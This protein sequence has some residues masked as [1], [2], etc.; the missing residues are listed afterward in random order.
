MPKM[1]NPWLALATPL[2]NR[3]G[4]G[5]ED[6]AT[7]KPAKHAA[8][9]PPAPTQPSRMAIVPQELVEMSVGNPWT[10]SPR[11]LEVLHLAVRGMNRAQIGAELG[12]QLHTVSQHLSLIRQKMYVAT[13]A[14]AVYAWHQYNRVIQADPAENKDNTLI[15]NLQRAIASMEKKTGT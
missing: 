11:Q 13:T 7:D 9:P 14:Q 15:A 1:P 2:R 4:C 12:I 6:R 8:P 10:L 5:R 3:P